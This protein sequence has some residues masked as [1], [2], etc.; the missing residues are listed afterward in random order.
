MND[1]RVKYRLHLWIIKTALVPLK[2]K[3]NVTDKWINRHA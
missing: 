1:F 3:G 2:F